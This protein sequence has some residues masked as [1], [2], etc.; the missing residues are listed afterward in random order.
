MIDHGHLHRP[1]L[2]LQLQPEL[3]LHSLEDR[4]P[5]IRIRRRGRTAARISN[6]AMAPSNQLLEN[7][8]SFTP[9]SSVHSIESAGFPDYPRRLI[10][11]H[12]I[13]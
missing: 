8:C 9:N 7:E 12:A 1:L 6:W 3:F 10:E 4:Q 2:L 13:V 5:A 11:L